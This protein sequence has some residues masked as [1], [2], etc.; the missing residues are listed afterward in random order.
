MT[1][2]TPQQM[3]K[4]K[5]EKKRQGKP[6][7]GGYLTLEEKKLFTDTTKLGGYEDEKTML[8]AAVAALHAELCK[9]A[10]N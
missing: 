3:A 6:R 1:N 8:L 10:A 5:Y 2:K 9:K 7:Y 4:A